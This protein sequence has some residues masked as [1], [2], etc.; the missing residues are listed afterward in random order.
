M[1]SFLD[2][3]ATAKTTESTS[4]EALGI[5]AGAAAMQG[6]R[7][8]MEVRGGLGEGQR[9]NCS[10]LSTIASAH[11]APHST[12]PLPTHR[13]TRTPSSWACLATPTT[14]GSPCLMVMEAT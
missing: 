5:K 12:L 2:K 9:G 11:P 3:P 8:S 6:W 7:I 1:G 10:E 13:R 4:D 14:A